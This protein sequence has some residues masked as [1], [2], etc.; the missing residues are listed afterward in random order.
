MKTVLFLALFVVVASADAQKY[1]KPNIDVP[2]QWSQPLPAPPSNDREAARTWWRLFND[3]TLSSLVAGALESNLDLRTAAMRGS[4]ARGALGVARSALQP[5]IAT[6]EGYTRVRGG[7]AQG[8][9]RA[10]ISSGSPQSRA[11]LI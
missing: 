8:L 6:S 1:E 5:S 10:G 4:E 7:I 3:P 11:S 9:T 2:A